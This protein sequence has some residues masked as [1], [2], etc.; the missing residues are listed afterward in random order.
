[1]VLL[2]GFDS[3]WTPGN[4][5]AVIGVVRSED[6]G[7]RELGP[8]LDVNFPQATETI[9]RWQTELRP[10]STIVMLDQPTIV[11]NEG[12]QR[13][14]E[15]IACASLKQKGEKRRCEAHAGGTPLPAHTDE[16][17]VGDDK[18]RSGWTQFARR[19]RRERAIR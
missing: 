4:S 14:V 11:P 6:G 5:G 15:N 3:A 9:F 19:T 16:L 2:I 18:P 13:P 12:G 17:P 10:Q 1:M 7:Y 8:P